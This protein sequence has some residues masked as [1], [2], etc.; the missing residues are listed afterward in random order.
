M[1]E[2][3]IDGSYKNST[4]KKCFIVII[5]FAYFNCV[6]SRNGNEW[7]LWEVFSFWYK[8]RRLVFLNDKTYLTM[9]H[10]KYS[11]LENKQHIFATSFY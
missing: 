2:R 10:K 6:H 4:I 11:N 3:A 1:Y 8:L 9:S 5:Q 7:N